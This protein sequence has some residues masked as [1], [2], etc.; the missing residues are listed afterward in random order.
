MVDEKEIPL[1]APFQMRAVAFLDVLGF[2]QLVKAAEWSHPEHRELQTLISLVSSHVRFDNDKLAKEVPKAVRPDYLF[3]SDSIIVSVPLTHEAGYDGLA[4]VAIKSIQIAQRLLEYG[5]LV[6]GAMS[7]GP[8]M[9]DLKNI[10]GSAY[11]AA[12]IAQEKEAK[13]PRIIMTEPAKKHYESAKHLK[14]SLDSLGLWTTY[15]KE[16]ILDIFQPSYFRGAE[17]YGGIEHAFLSLELMIQKRL[18][19]LPLGSEARSK[20]EWMA[21]FY[22]DALKRHR[23]TR[24]ARGFETMPVPLSQQVNDGNEHQTMA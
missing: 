6:R 8:V 18:E 21:A 16:P 17:G 1:I 9:H 2:S 5:F 24:P 11:M 23:I 13:H 4:I 7:V 15:E 20:W 14:H 3:V 10:F 19:T 12:Y 22:N